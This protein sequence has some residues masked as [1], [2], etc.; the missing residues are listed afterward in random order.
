PPRG[1]AQGYDASVMDWSREGDVYSNEPETRAVWPGYRPATPGARR[2]LLFDPQTGKLAYPFLRPH[3]GKRPP[4]APNHGPAPFLDP[5]GSGPDPAAPGADGPGSLCPAGT[6]LRT[7]FIR[8]IT[9]PVTYDR[10]DDIVDSAGEIYVLKQDEAG[11]RA[12]PTLRRPLAIRAN[13]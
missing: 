2:A 6:R 13:A 9:I 3:L 10:K 8:A 12:S 4:F 7:F 5:G 1:V 11:V